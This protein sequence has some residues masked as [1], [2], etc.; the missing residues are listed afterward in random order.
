MKLDFS[1]G[2][3]KNVIMR[4]IKSDN[5]YLVLVFSSLFIL[6]FFLILVLNEFFKLEFKL[7]LKC[8][9]SFLSTLFLMFFIKS[10]VYFDRNSIYLKNIFGVTLK[11]IELKS[12]KGKKIKKNPFTAKNILLLFGDKYD[13]MISIKLDLINSKKH[14]INGR[15]FSNEGLKE[16]INLI[17]P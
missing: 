5:K 4:K 9:L 3:I 2:N 14:T 13:D 7:L 12:I 1:F 15:L 16:F 8:I 6:M 17:K 10:F 11:T